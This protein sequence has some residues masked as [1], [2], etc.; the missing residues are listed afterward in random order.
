MIT[1]VCRMKALFLLCGI[2]VCACFLATET[3][4]GQTQTPPTLTSTS[5][6]NNQSIPASPTINSG[7]Q[8]GDIFFR[9]RNSFIFS[10]NADESYQDNAYYLGNGNQVPDYTTRLTGRIAY[11]REQGRT[12][13]GLDFSFGRLLYLHG[14]QYD[15]NI[16]DGGVNIS[17][18]AT[19]RWTITIGDR[20]GYLPQSGNFQ[21][22]DSIL[23][24]VPP[25]DAP[26]NSILLP[27][28]QSILNTVHF[29][30]TYL[31][32]RRSGLT[33]SAANS[34]NLYSQDNLRDQNST[35]ASMGYSYQLS[36]RNSIEL[37]YQ[38][39][40]FNSANNTTPSTGGQ[41]TQANLVRS[42]VAYLGI[43]RQFSPSL[44]GSIGGGAV[45]MF[46][47]SIDLTTG[48]RYR[49]NPKPIMIGN[50]TYSPT[51]DPRTFL[52]LQAGQRISN[53]AGVGSISLIQT[54]SASLG[55]RFTRKITG[56]ID[57]GYSRN[58]FLSDFDTLGHSN[59][60]DGFNGG[61]RLSINFLERLNFY[62]D[63]RRFQQTS[64]GFNTVI[65][66]QMDGNIVTVGIGYSFP[67]FY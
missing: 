45:T 15:Q 48:N 46:S 13:T 40:Y 22:H 17:Y 25:L 11:R 10:L 3:I 65:P 56:S 42:H 19:P 47:D 49:P 12:T 63:Y 35:F 14:N 18:R 50:I 58:Q 31:M 39:G 51:F 16:A 62:A 52:S 57:G 32:S 4:W 30:S 67:W 26:N 43:S 66:G 29:S 61:A 28:N 33:F 27:L 8:L 60:A 38:F 36:Q 34:I 24:P 44:T 64:T 9:S 55:R 53:G 54:V 1:R 37:V 23:N 2:G 41:I 7:S 20:V 21:R 6:G 59:T 5:A